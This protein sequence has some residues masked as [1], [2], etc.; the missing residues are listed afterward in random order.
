MPSARS[1]SR[2]GFF[3]FSFENRVQQPDYRYRKNRKREICFGSPEPEFHTIHY[4][5]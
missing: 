4:Y 3:D 2:R 1:I 5:S